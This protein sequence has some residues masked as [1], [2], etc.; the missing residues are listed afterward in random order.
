MMRKLTLNCFLIIDRK[1]ILKSC[2]EFCSGV[3]TGIRN[4]QK[5]LKCTPKPIRRKLLRKPPSNERNKNARLN[6]A[7]LMKIGKNRKNDFFKRKKFN[8]DHSRGYLYYY[9]GLRK[10]ER[11]LSR[12]QIEEGLD[13]LGA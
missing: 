3:K 9:R 10:D 6:S 5:L 12:R 13:R 4:G 7:R 8:F 2:V 11:I 1:I